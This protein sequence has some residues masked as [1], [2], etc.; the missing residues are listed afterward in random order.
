MAGGGWHRHPAGVFHWLE[1]SATGS[2]LVSVPKP[3]SMM[4]SLV[5]PFTVVLDF[6][7]FLIPCQKG[8]RR[9]AWR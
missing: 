1:A 2:Y 6:F 8:E 9:P 7:L 5:R 3:A 4:G